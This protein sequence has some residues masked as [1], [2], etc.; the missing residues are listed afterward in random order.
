MP[1]IS[2]ASTT[3]H[4]QRFS[5][6]IPPNTASRKQ[7]PIKMHFAA[8]FSTLAV[9]ASAAPFQTLMRI[10]AIDAYRWNVTE[11]KA[12]CANSTCTYGK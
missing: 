4:L 5:Q 9:A 11:W 10:Q 12:G 8:V 6:L 7:K 2:S 3:G 1:A